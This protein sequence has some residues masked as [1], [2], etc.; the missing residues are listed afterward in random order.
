MKTR[1]LLLFVVTLVSL[2]VAIGQSRDATV[3]K[4]DQTLTLDCN[5]NGLTVSGDDN[6]LTV[7]GSCITLTVS[8]DDNLIQAATV[9]ELVVSG[10]DNNVNVDAVAK[11]S[12]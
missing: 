5:G 11:I 4:D 2:A 9:L 12:A 6:K 1:V 3:D 10:D 8:G 7:R